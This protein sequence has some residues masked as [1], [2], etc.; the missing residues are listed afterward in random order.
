M[1]DALA[2]ARDLIRCPS[3][4]P[5]EGGALRCLEGLL[6][7]S[8]F[9]CERVT[10]SEEGT[11]DVENLFARYGAGAPCLLFAGHTDV[12][13][14]GDEA[15]WLRAPFAGDV[16][17][18]F[19]Y[20]RGAVDM[21]GGVAA[22]A[23]AALA[24]VKEHAAFEGSI[25]FLITGDE[26]G[27]AVNG[28]IKLLKWARDKGERFDHCILGEPTNPQTLSDMIKIGRRGSLTGTIVVHGKQGHVGYPAL[29]DNPIR[30]L[31]KLLAALQDEPIDD[32]TE[33]FEPSNLEFS[34]VDVGNSSSNVIPAEA[35]AVFNV[36]FN[37]RWTHE[38]LGTEIRRR[39][40]KAAGE[41]VRFTLTFAPSNSSAFL[42]TPGPFVDLVARA[43]EA[44]TGTRP[45]LSTTGGT[46]DARFIKDYCEV[47]EYGLVGETMHQIDERVAIADLEG[48]TRIY[49]RII[50][51]YFSG[52]RI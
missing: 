12:V 26:E 46:S 15:R 22:F 13:P 23:A 32:G 4:T 9:A 3:I 5:H 52:G 6:S 25:A 11:P 40:E 30:G 45:A 2:I 44:E 36:R 1:T 7:A 16:K 10:F 39:C 24:Y 20:G 29:A 17:D 21:K 47:V 50:D 14:A 34:T 28:T 37:D 33:H 49:R 43:V 19:L 35:R 27:P 38:T 48:L 18:G 42:T 41:S 8:G 31:T 51:D